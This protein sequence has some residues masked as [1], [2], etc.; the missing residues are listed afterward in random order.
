MGASVELQKAVYNALN[1]TYPVYDDVSTPLQMP[2]I[3]IGDETLNRNDPKGEQLSE[4]VLTIHSFSNYSGSKQAK[5]MNEYII[6]KLVDQRI[7]VTGFT[8]CRNGLELAE[9]NKE[10]DANRVT[11]SDN[12][13]IYHGIVQVRFHLYKDS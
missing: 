5:E 13:I 7:T 8:V 9:V 12:V 10:L 1:G 4:F 3:L 6:N 11:L 2:Y